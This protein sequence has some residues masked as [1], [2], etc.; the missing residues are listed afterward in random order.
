MM[1][2]VPARLMASACSC[3]VDSHTAPHGDTVLLIDLDGVLCAACQL[4]GV[5]V[6]VHGA[7]SDTAVLWA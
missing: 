3:G 1:F 2:Q 6:V 4:H 7:P 5:F